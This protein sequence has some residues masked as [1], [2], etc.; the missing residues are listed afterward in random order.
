MLRLARE[1]PR[2]HAAWLKTRPGT[3][4]E[5]GMDAE[6]ADASS[7]QASPAETAEEPVHTAA[8][9][10]GDVQTAAE[11]H[12]HHEASIMQ[13]TQQIIAAEPAAPP[14][15]PGVAHA[16]VRPV[17]AAA[18]HE[19][20]TGARIAMSGNAASRVPPTLTRPDPASDG[21][22][23]N[24]DSTRCGGGQPSSTR[25]GGPAAPE[26]SPERPVVRF[27][28]QVTQAPR[29]PSSPTRRSANVRVWLPAA[30]S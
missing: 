6:K 16:G 30:T 27:S 12:A 3:G 22:P 8:G 25:D 4:H 13:S 14:H 17:A 20:S 9:N 18:A 2:L 19:V 24:D 5:T 28:L 15:A 10:S 7:T 11:Q 26:G 1:N 29:P 23:S 21:Q